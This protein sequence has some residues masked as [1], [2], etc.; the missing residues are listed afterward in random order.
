M[1]IE[2]MLELL[3][4]HKILKEA[5]VSLPTKKLMQDRYKILLDEFKK[6]YKLPYNSSKD[7]LTD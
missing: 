6:Q 3:L 7:P 5:Y 1:I 4:L 2:K